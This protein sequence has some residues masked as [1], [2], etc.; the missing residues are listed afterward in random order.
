MDKLYKLSPSDFAYLWNDCKHCYYQKVKFGISHSGVFPS[1]FTRINTLL[2]NSIMGMNLSDIHPD[3]PNGIIEIQ[4]GYMKSKPVTDTN[5]FLSG[6]FDI[7]TKLDD[8]T[9]AII[10]FKIT[11]PNEEKISKYVSQLHAYKFAL[12]NPSEGEPIKISKMGVVSINPDEMKLVDGK[13]I[14]TTTPKWHPVKEDMNG[15]YELIKEISTV[16]NGNLPRNPSAITDIEICKFLVALTRTRKQ[17][18]ILC[19]TNFAGKRVNPSEFIRWMG[20]ENL[21]IIK[22]D[23]S[24]WRNIQA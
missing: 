3:L 22:I 21:D 1:M 2:Q 4:E 20:D 8:G 18:H 7:L 12:E 17:C 14:F 11:T 10:D 13:V 6:R 23:K 16:L 15:F 9:Y 19:T 24:Y 5:C